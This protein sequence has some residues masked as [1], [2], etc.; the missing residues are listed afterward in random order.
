MADFDI[1]PA[2]AE[3]SLEIVRL[4]REVTNP[5]VIS[6]LI[7]GCAGAATYVKL[8][9]EAEGPTNR[10]YFV[11]IRDG[12]IAACADFTVSLDVLSL[13][14]VATALHSRRQG[15]GNA[16]LK[17]AIA[18]LRGP[19]PWVELD[20]STDNVAALSWYSG[21]GFAAVSQSTYWEFANDEDPACPSMELSDWPQA[22]AC[23]AAFGFSEFHVATPSTRVLVG[24]VGG[25][26]FRLPTA[27]AV[28]DREVRGA[29]RAID[30][31]RRI[32]AV[33]PDGPAA[34]WIEAHGT[35]VRTTQH[36]RASLPALCGRLERPRL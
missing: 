13:K 4:I 2:R 10:R 21:L 34:P 15:L 16:L 29:L 20:V 9:L 19:Q 25:A 27:E 8:H 26:W 11:A 12:R 23:H 3:D 18:S 24:R 22:Q 14:Y 1:R 32:Y 36:M 30:A 28:C 35:R 17:V 31:T 7:Y 33:L 6:K 5:S